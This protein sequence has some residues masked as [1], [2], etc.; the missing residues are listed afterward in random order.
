MPAW[1]RDERKERRDNCGNVD[2][3]C[4][5]RKKRGI[6]CTVSKDG[7]IGQCHGYFRPGSAVDSVEKSDE[8]REDTNKR[9]RAHKRLR[10]T[11]MSSAAAGGIERGVKWTR[12]H[13]LVRGIR[14]ASG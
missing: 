1:N 3:N 10:L 7:D 13:N 12:F 5:C 2:A 11:R 4:T 6:S 9:E 8:E 14:A